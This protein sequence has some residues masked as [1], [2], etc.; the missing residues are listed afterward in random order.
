VVTRVVEVSPPLERNGSVVAV[1]GHQAAATGDAERVV[2]R[3][4]VDLAVPTLSELGADVE[5]IHLMVRRGDLVRI[6]PELVMLPSQVE[7]LTEVIRGLDDGFTI[8][9]FRER[10]GLSRKYA[11][12]VLEWSDREGLTVRRGDSRWPR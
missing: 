10:T 4:G 5:L 6:S 2:A 3:L 11:I 8:A 1:K 7:H 12:P 9:D